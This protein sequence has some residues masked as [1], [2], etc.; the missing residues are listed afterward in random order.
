[1]A[2]AIGEEVFFLEAEGAAELGGAFA[3]EQRVVGAAHHFEGEAGDV[4]SLAE[5][6]P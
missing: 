1:M 5:V 4:H 3:D 6:L 2:G